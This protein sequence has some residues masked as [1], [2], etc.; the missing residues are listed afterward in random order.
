MVAQERPDTMAWVKENS[1]T[2]DKEAACV[3]VQCFGYYSKA[4]VRVLCLNNL[5]RNEFVVDLK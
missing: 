4:W 3:Q 5:L 2:F 1:P